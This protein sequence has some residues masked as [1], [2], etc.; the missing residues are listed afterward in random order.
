MPL[1]D[2][3]RDTKSDFHFE[4]LAHIKLLDY[5]TKRWCNIAS[6]FL[7]AV[8]NVGWKRRMVDSGQDGLNFAK[9]RVAKVCNGE[10]A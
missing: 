1:G 2:F 5:V 3:V 4:S 10:G 8:M 9:N 6:C 7:S